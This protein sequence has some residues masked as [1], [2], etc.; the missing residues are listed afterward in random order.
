MLRYEVPI[1]Y[2]VLMQL[3]PFSHWPE[4]PFEVVKAVCE[5]SR[6]LSLKKAKFFRYLEEYRL[7]GLY[8]RR[9]KRL[10][11]ERRSYYQ[12]LREKKLN[13]YIRKNRLQIDGIGKSKV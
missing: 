8:C 1:V 9:P 4:P 7:T 12:R 3:L 11:P 10:T 13:H 5:A 6:D 2:S